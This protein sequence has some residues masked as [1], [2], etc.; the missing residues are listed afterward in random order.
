MCE[1]GNEVILMAMVAKI[2]VGFV[3]VNGNEYPKC[4]DMFTCNLDVMETNTK[5]NHIRVN[6]LLSVK[7][8]YNRK[9]IVTPVKQN[10]SVM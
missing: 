3:M 6:F 4:H 5:G 2:V 10:R 7:S 8:V 9:S 1:V